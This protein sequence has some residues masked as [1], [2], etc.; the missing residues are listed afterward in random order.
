MLHVPSCHQ[1]NF[2]LEDFVSM[3]SFVDKQVCMKQGLLDRLLKYASEIK[4]LQER[5][6]ILLF[7]FRLSCITLVFMA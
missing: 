6:W 7:L 5:Y 2:I 4:E 3:I 1:I